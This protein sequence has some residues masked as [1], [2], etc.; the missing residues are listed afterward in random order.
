MSDVNRQLDASARVMRVVG[1]L[2]ILGLP[3]A[4]FGYTPGF[5]WG[6]HPADFPALVPHPES[7]LDGLH[8]YLYMILS[9]YIGWAILL[10]RG[11]RNPV[12]AASLFDWGIVA[13]GLH[14]LLM[15]PQA[16]IYPNE[17]AHLWADIP[18]QLAVCA[19]MW[20]WH[21]TRR[22]GHGVGL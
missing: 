15:V 2:I 17:H 7:H 10:I 16:F 4:I 20:Y 1:W 12:A 3:V 11:A 18:L 5:M 19:V 22:D 13:N 8:P 14:A 21:P 9:L 6:S